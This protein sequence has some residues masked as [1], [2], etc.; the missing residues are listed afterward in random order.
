[1]PDTNDDKILPSDEDHKPAGEFDSS[2]YVS[3]EDDT[4]GDAVP[5]AG[6]SHVARGTPPGGASSSDVSQEKLRGIFSTQSILKVGTGTTVRKT[7]QKT[8]WMV[9]E[10]D[11]GLIQIQ[12]LNLNYIP[13]GPKRRIAKEDLLQKFSPEPEFY[14]HT[15]FPA[16]QQQNLAVDK[17][18]KHRDKG[19]YFSAE[20]QFQQALKVDVDNVRANF[21]LGLTY[22]G[23]GEANKADNIFERL[24]KLDAAFEEEHKHLFNE[25]GISLRKNKMYDQALEYYERAMELA[26]ADEHLHYNIARTYFE[27]DQVGKAVEHLKKALLMNPDLEPAQLFLKWMAER[28]ILSK[29]D[30]VDAGAT[31]QATT[32]TTTDN[33]N[34]ATGDAPAETQPPLDFNVD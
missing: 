30:A 22:M 17:G 29:D 3:L 4:G 7:I 1:M 27:K 24:V 28:G 26:K 13:S 34:A 31:L 11:Q 8:F 33:G 10:S 21:G 5:V 12:P 25:F 9:E 18:E 20:V 2:D 19:E 14:L 16:I 15:V 23:R 6:A 32:Q